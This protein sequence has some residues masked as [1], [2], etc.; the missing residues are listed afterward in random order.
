MGG[1]EPGDSAVLWRVNGLN[2]NKSAPLC[3]ALFGRL[4]SELA[5]ITL[6]ELNVPPEPACPLCRAKPD[7]LAVEEH[8]LNVIVDEAVGYGELAP[9]PARH[10]QSEGALVGTHPHSGAV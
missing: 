2:Y 6:E 7:V 8:R 9:K 3:H 10:A 4:G 5:S 1:S